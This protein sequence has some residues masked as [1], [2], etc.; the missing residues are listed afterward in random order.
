MSGPRPL[1]LLALLC[2]TPPAAA[3]EATAP[4]VEL[5]A[6]A[7]YPYA[8][9]WDEPAY[10]SLLKSADAVAE[11]ARL[12]LEV[13]PPTEFQVTRP[14]NPNVLAGSDAAQA[15]SRRGHPARAFAALRAWAERSGARTVSS[16]NQG[17]VAAS[18]LRDESTVVA[19]VQVVDAATGDVLARASG[20]VPAAE[21]PSPAGDPLPQLTSLHRRLLAEALRD[22]AARL[23]PGRAARAPARPLEP[24]AFE[25][26][27][28]PGRPS[29]R[30]T[31]ARD[32]VA[33]AAARREIASYLSALRER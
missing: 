10:R 6:L 4:P 1:L 8:F 12:P 11:A 31:A 22:L 3:A 25:P 24:S 27:G 17:G 19:H 20:R 9:G 29:L 16:A 30:E 5:R 32:P 26:F 7:V 23:P 33:G 21:E 2:R 28:L 13:I 14:E 18:A 15:V